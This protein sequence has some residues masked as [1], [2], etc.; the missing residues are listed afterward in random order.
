MNK[1]SSIAFFTLFALVSFSALS[2]PGAPPEAREAA[3]AQILKD[4]DAIDVGGGALPGPLILMGDDAFPLAECRNYDGTC[5]FAAAGAFHGRGRAVYLAHP[6]YLTSRPFQRDTATFLKQSVDWVAGGKS[7]AKIAV[8]RN[9]KAVEAFKE[10]GF[11]DV[12]MISHADKLKGF[13]V[14]IAGNFQKDEVPPVLD[15][16]K[17]GGGLVAAGLG[18]GFLYYA[19]DANFAEDFIDNRVIG[20]MGILMGSVGSSRIDGAFPTACDKIPSGTLV[21]DALALAIKGEFASTAERKQVTKTLT[22]LIDALPNGVRP[23]VDAKLLELASRP[24]ASALPSP[25]KPVGSESV[26]ARLAITARKNAWLAEP[27][28][29][30]PADPAAAVYPGLVKPDTPSIQRC[31]GIDLAIPRWHSTGV[32]APAGQALT[33]TLDKDALDLGLKVRVGSTADDLSGCDEWRRAPRVTIEIPLVKETTT[34]ATPYGGLVYIV[35]P[36]GARKRRVDVGLDGGVMAP[37]F[38]LGRDANDAFIRDC[39]KTGAPYGEIEGT[40]FIL[41]VQTSQLAQVADPEWIAAFWDRALDAAQHLAQWDRRESPER[42]CS[43]VQLATGWLHNGYPLMYHVNTGNPLDWV[44]DKDG[45][46]R[47]EGWGPF[48]E[49]GHNHQHG[50]WTPE[51]TA[52]V[53]VNLFTCYI[54]ETVCGANIREERFPSGRRQQDSR[55]KRWVAKGRK[56]DDWKANPFLA[57]DMYL[58]IK[59]AYGWDVFIQTFARYRQPGFRRPA[60][61]AEKWNIFA[62]EISAAANADLAAAMDVWSIPLSPETLADCS[63]LPPA[64]PRITKGLVQTPYVSP[65]SKPITGL[66]LGVCLA[67]PDAGKIETYPSREAVPGGE[68]DVRWK[69]DWMLFRRIEPTPAPTRIGR[70]GAD[71]KASDAEREIEISSPY[72]LAIYE[73]TQRQWFNVMETWKPNCFGAKGDRETRPVNGVSHNEARGST[74]DGINWPKTGRQVAANSFLGRLR[75][76]AGSQIEFDLPTEAQWEYA[77]RAGTT[78]KWNN[79]EDPQPYSTN[80]VRCDHV[81]DKLGRYAGNGGEPPP[82]ETLKPETKTPY[83]TAPAGSYLPNAW[84]LYDTHGNVYE[85]CLDWFWPAGEAPDVS[86]KDPQGPPEPRDSKAPRR[87][88]RG[89]SY[90]SSRFGSA[91]AAANW[92]RWLGDLCDPG[93]AHG[94]VGLRVCM[95]A[96]IALAPQLPA[97]AEP[98]SPAALAARADLVRGVRFL[99]SAGLPG[100]VYVTATNAFPLVAARNWDRSPACMAAAAFHGK[101]R[102]VVVAD[103]VF[104][105]SLGDNAIFRRNAQTWLEGGALGEVQVRDVGRL[106]AAEAASLARWVERGGGLFAHG[107]AWPWRRR[108]AAETGAARI[109][110]W[111][112]NIALQPYGLMIG[113]FCVSRTSS[114]GFGA[115]RPCEEDS[116]VAPAEVFSI[117][118]LRK[119]PP[120]VPTPKTERDANGLLVR[121]GDTIAF[122]GDSITRLGGEKFGYIDLV[123]Q[124]L[125][126]VGVTNV[127]KVLAGVDGNHS[128]DM[129]NRSGAIL[130]NPEIKIMT[131]SCGVNDVWGYDW[132]RGV[133]LEDYMHNVRAIYNKAATAGVLVVAMT[134]T[135]IQEDPAFEKNRILD[136]YADFIRAEAKARGLPLAD[137]RADQIAALATLPPDSG[138]HFTYDGVHPVWEGHKLLAKAVLKA[139]G[140]PEAKLPD[141]EKAWN[142]KKAAS[143]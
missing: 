21:D 24:E 96:E 136:P 126:T 37:W 77:A 45:L 4:V 107:R 72:Y 83:G 115:R 127:N 56:F 53:T 32:F 9:A 99:D 68:R 44:I 85:H 80:N 112:G 120:A 36:K 101:G 71:P 128:G 69:T 75:A 50:D 10:L 88:M 28:K 41:T 67:G 1:F 35:V 62:R 106:S 121:P 125:E 48:H 129:L 6:A 92:Q 141:I 7:K 131:V 84:G 76:L 86:G 124:G 13:D 105:E 133:E 78:N 110:D 108:T 22:H 16:V 74:G 11:K 109:A 82:G 63:K 34:F 135:L 30:W 52:E 60:N 94:A 43:D 81:L 64:D 90:W 118:R 119:S 33:V 46:E 140:V 3:R 17:Q 40:N 87:V 139:L 73:V 12:E 95:P 49:I 91:D 23:D 142:K 117:Q 27:E 114:E 70:P 57:L 5:A 98:L 42:I 137:P 66:Y 111:P 103:D 138:R 134:P 54:I 102:V 132:G 58:R 25:D 123:L 61:N 31:V 93:T 18:W 29:L 100:P 122:L 39:A 51:G 65:P 113:D 104:D 26:F 143:R 14:L 97:G 116:A 47:G 89:G 2:A 55:V 59:E 130:A 15:F 20:P 8:L 38:K 79:G 19:P